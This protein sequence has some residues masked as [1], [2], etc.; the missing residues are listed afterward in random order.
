M[1]FYGSSKCTERCVTIAAL[2]G[3]LP[4]CTASAQNNASE[5][6]FPAGSAPA[7]VSPLSGLTLLDV[8]KA[9]LVKN[10]QLKIQQY[11]VDAQSGVLRSATGKFDW[12]IQA[13]GSRQITYD[14]VAF[15]A[16]PTNPAELAEFTNFT[17]TS[18]SAIKQLRN[19]TVLA[20]TL[21]INR[22]ADQ[23]DYPGG[24]N[25]AQVG[26]AIEIPLLR[27]RGK[28]AV[29]AQEI[30]AAKQVEAARLDLSQL[31]SDTLATAAN[32]Y[33]AF[34]AAD[35]TLAV[36]KASESRGSDLL[37]GT[38]TLVEADRLPANDLN[39]ARANLASRME[40]V[41][42]SEQNLLQARQQL[43]LV[44]GL[45]AEQILSLPAPTQNIP[46]IVSPFSPALLQKYIQLASTHRADVL[47]A[48]LRAESNLVLER[49]TQN[50]LKPQLDIVSNIGY[51][52]FHGGTTFSDLPNS[53]VTGPKEPTYT[54]GL[55]Y[56]QSPANNIAK[57]QLQSEVA[58]TRQ[59]QVILAET[60][61]V[62]ATGAVVAFQGVL[63]TVKQL[64]KAREA[65][66]Y[67]QAALD[68]ERE[69]YRLSLSSLVDVLTV[70]DRL[71]SVLIDEVSARLAY[72][73]ALVQLRQAT[74]TIVQAG[75]DVQYVN[76]DIFSM[77]PNVD[78]SQ[79]TESLVAQ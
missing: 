28:N 47:A 49:A 59:C 26:L 48:T 24:I 45:N 18:V 52:G 41:T 25:K 61:R 63:S 27:N 16:I 68:G 56:S 54:V 75:Q 66:R 70:E 74:G 53:L 44:M 8:L 10:P 40:S 64:Q 76:P 38:E 58:T 4:L 17:D 2:C 57:G 62:A 19:G 42:A 43:V 77:M 20:P 46:D 55:T 23:V 6:Q 39:Q 51:A 50:Q 15:G 11:N 33:W 7:V 71:T 73:L 14:P 78:D 69:K 36:Y 31:I 67:Y 30:S 21:Q 37:R 60:A 3:Y 5:V 1:K 13:N 12:T 29:D 72:A 9:S 22:T 65:V 79:T 35:A 32:R 34:V